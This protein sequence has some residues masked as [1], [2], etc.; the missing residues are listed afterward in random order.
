MRAA[1]GLSFGQWPRR[2][3]CSDTARSSASAPTDRTALRPLSAGQTPQFVLGFADMKAMLGDAMGQPVT[4]EFPDPNGTGDVHQ[5]TTTGPA[6][7]RKSTNT[8]TFTNG[9][10]HWANTPSGWVYWTGSSID[11]VAD[12]QPW[13][14]DAQAPVTR[15]PAAPASAA[16]KRAGLAVLS[17][18]LS[19]QRRCQAPVSAPTPAA[20]CRHPRATASR[21]PPTVSA[22]FDPRQ[23]IGQGDRYNCGDFTREQAQSVLEADPSDPNRLDADNNG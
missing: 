15:S 21:R 5:Q 2:P 22:G 4:C 6:F 11:P 20:D 13:P 23:Y 17:A 10:E 3:P 9:S 12:A 16:G 18:P 7:W 14:L 8:P 1:A 19:H